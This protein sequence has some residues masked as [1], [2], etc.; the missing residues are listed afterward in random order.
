[1]SILVID[2]DDVTTIPVL[3]VIVP[4]VDDDHVVPLVEYKTVKLVTLLSAS[5]MVVVT[6]TTEAVVWEGVMAVTVGAEFDR[7]E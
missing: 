2:P 3:T 7:A 5:E 1:V 6:V 4:R